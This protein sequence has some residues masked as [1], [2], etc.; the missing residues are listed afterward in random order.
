M[1]L[2]KKK[3]LVTGGAGFLG[4]HV[5]RRLLEKGIKEQNILV[6]RI[7]NY[8]LRLIENCEKVVKGQNLVIHL[9]GLTGGIEYHKQ[10]PATI[11]YDNL[12]MGIQLME[13]ARKAEVEKFITIGSAT[14]Y[15]ENAPLPFRESD[16][17]RGF[18][19]P[20]HAPYTVAKKMLLVQAQAY[21]KQ[22]DFNAIHLLMTN[23]YGPG[24]KLDSSFVIPSLI[25]RIWQAE[26]ENQNFIE[27]WGTGKPTRDF[28]YVGDA[29]E[30]IIKAAESY[31][32]PEPVNIG[33][34]WEIS[35]K[36]LTG[37]IVRLMNFKGEVRFDETKPDGQMRRM[38]DTTRA[39]QEFDF[40]A[41]TDFEVG[42]KKAIGWY[43]PKIE[44]LFQK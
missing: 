43:I 16:L 14:E 12:M 39:E 24:E 34:G 22:Y 33:S 13:A 19:E 37:I 27:I 44:K 42:L 11:F 26:K 29:A 36:E 9:A 3:I 1:N 41:S 31:N 28:L 20:I 6:P 30:G 7:E 38:M 35:I 5:V 23:M 25:R 15:P 2:K 4:Q 40:K 17:W 18:P 10:N 32:K 21:R 8:D